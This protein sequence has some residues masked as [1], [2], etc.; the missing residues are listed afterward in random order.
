MLRETIAFSNMNT[1]SFDV[2]VLLLAFNRPNTICDVFDQIRKIKPST[3]YIFSDAPRD[4]QPE[5]NELVEICRHLMDESQ[6]NW[7]CKVARWYAD[8][9]IGRAVG[10]S[11][12]ISW[13][14]ETSDRLI[15]L[16]ENCVPH[17][18]FFTFCRQMLDK[19]QFNDRVMHVSGLRRVGE[20]EENNFDHFFIHVADIYGWATWKRAWNRFDFWMEQYTEP[21]SKK[22]LQKL[23]GSGSTAKYWNGKF[24]E[25]YLKEQKQSWFYQWQYAIFLN[26]GL[27]VIPNVNLISKLVPEGS[28]HA[29]R[30]HFD[31]NVAWRNRLT[32][33]PSV[34]KTSHKLY[35][36][37]P[38]YSKDNQ[39]IRR[40]LNY[41]RFSL[42]KYKTF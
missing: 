29:Y 23:L 25:A 41:V 32:D 17:R 31:R 11:S 19:Y 21:D 20:L 42:K 1:D 37:E 14:F 34:V 40:I 7:D 28:D 4:D 24:C 2:P 10:T 33:A 9:H 6:I 16:E 26:N 27:A 36:E 13:A 30:S 35:L 15:V 39:S 3:L 18:T 5:D 12:A 38:R 22:I 8:K